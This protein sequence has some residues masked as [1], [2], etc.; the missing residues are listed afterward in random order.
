MARIGI[1]I[2]IAIIIVSMGSAMYMYT[3]YQT[4]FIIG[5]MGE[6]V[7]VGPVE[8]AISFDGTHKGNKETI[9]ENTFVK[10]K[11]IA[12]NITDEQTRISGGQFYLVDEK[13][14]KHQAVYGGFSA[15]DLRDYLLEPNKPVMFTTQ[16]DVPYDEQKQY[17]ITIRPTKQQSSLDTAVICITNC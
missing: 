14:Q 4:N 10:I 13:Q 12:K 2:V 11:I 16:F 7:V 6:P 8:Y 5:K 15:D 17:S 1:I 9:P 3:Q